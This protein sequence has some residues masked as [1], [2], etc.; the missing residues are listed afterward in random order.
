MHC[1]LG[2]IS[3]PLTSVVER[4]SDD[5]I[6]HH[7]FPRVSLSLAIT[8][9]FKLETSSMRESFK[10]TMETCVIN[11]R[12][13]PQYACVSNVLDNSKHIVD[14]QELYLIVLQ[15]RTTFNLHLSSKSEKPKALHRLSTT[16]Q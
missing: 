4:Q 16:Y 1:L 7:S 8:S 5:I 13:N 12:Q 10:P 6:S 14:R 15:L 9:R 2:Q 11:I 3:L